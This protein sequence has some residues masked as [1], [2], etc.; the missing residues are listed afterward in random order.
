[1]G[2]LGDTEVI[3]IE[4]AP[5]NMMPYTVSFFLDRVSEG[6]YDGHAFNIN[7]GHV[8][9]ATPMKNDDLELVNTT[10]QEHNPNYPH[11]QYTLGF[12]TQERGRNFYFSTQDNSRPHGE[13]Q[14]T[15]FARVVEGREIVDRLSKMK[16]ENGNFGLL[17]E[18]A[19]IK[20]AVI[21]GTN[22]TEHSSTHYGFAE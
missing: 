6:F 9:I 7:A 18:F 3:V 13:V 17:T 16:N 8:L 12:T 22:E 4:M 5:L 1:M 20:K 2:Y 19:T 21:F 10:I 11:L 14:E 15:C